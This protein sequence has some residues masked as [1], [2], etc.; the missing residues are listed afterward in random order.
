MAKFIGAILLMF[1]TVGGAL[2]YLGH[3]VEALTSNDGLAY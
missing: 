3:K 1:L 2:M